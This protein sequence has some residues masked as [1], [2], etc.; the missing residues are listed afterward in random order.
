MIQ[1]PLGHILKSN[2]A[3]YKEEIK[4]LLHC[5]FFRKSLCASMKYFYTQSLLRPRGTSHNG[6]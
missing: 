2:F 1:A 5:T 4:D 3:H 6:L